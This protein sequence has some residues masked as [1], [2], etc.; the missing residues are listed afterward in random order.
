[1]IFRYRPR[2]IRFNPASS[3]R[4]AKHSGA[5]DHPEHRRVQRI[6]LFGQHGPLL[7]SRPPTL[8]IASSLLLARAYS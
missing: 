7:T 5:V 3:T 6:G 2:K 8:R 1:M 4:P